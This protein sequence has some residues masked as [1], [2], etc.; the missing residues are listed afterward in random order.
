MRPLKEGTPKMGTPI[1][2]LQMG[3]LKK[4]IPK[5]GTPIGGLQ[6]G[7]SKGRP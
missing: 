4:G 5:M 6:M 3:S 1:R 7:A 2:G